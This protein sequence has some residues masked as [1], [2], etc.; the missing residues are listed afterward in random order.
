MTIAFLDIEVVTSN[1]KIDN[2]GYLSDKSAFESTSISR[3][4]EACLNDDI[5][6]ICGHNF[7]DHDK[8]FL[9]KTGFNPI[10]EKVEI[11]DTLYLSMLLCTN[12]R[13]HKLD[14]PYKDTQINIE[15]QPLG[16]SEQT[17]ALFDSL[18]Q[19][20]DK[21]DEDIKSVFYQLLKDDLHFSGFFIYKDYQF[22]SI[23]V[24]QQIQSFIEIDKAQYLDIEK[25][26]PI[27][28]AFIISFLRL[29]DQGAISLVI[30]NKYPKV[31]EL[32]KKM[33]FNEDALDIKS[34]SV[35]EFNISKF[36][37]F[38]TRVSG[39]LFDS[40]KISQEEIVKASIGSESLLAIL[41]TG[42]GKTI[43]FQ[44]PALIKAQ[45][46]KGLSVVIS[47]LQALMKDQIDSFKRKNNNFKVIAISGY[48]SP[49]ER[50]NAIS[51]VENGIVDML[52]LAPEALRSNS[53]FNALKKR[54]IERFII[55]EAH[56]FSSWGHDFRHDYYFIANTIKELEESNFQPHIPVSCFTATA[57]PE[58]IKDIKKYFQ[59]KLNITLKE[60]IASVERYNLDYSIIKTDTA[61]D[62]YEKL[63]DILSDLERSENNKNPTIIYIP[64]NTKEC[65]ELS[66]KLQKDERLEEFNLVIEPFYS[67]LD[68][69]RENGKREQNSRG[70]I[71]ILADFISN[72]VNVV[73]ATTAFGMGIDK[74]DIQ[75]I[76]HYQQ[77]DSLESYI[78][79]SGRGARDE[80]LRAK[81]IVLYSKDDFD[82]SFNQLNRSK[83]DIAEIKR[84]VGVLKKYDNK[85]LN[86][87]PKDIARK[88]GVDIEDS[89]ID[90]KV[91]IKTALLELEKHK[92]IERGRDGYK[93]FATSIKKEE[94]KE[95]MPFVHEILDP[96]KEQDP[97]IELYQGMILVMQNIIQRS[98][99][100]PIEVD[101]LSDITGVEKSKIFKVL[102]QL[103]KDGL[104]KFDNDISVYIKKSVKKDFEKYF[105]V[106]RKVLNV[107]I[108][109]ND[110]K[111]INLRNFNESDT[112]NV[113]L[114]KQII[115][116]WSHLAKL[117]GGIFTARFKNDF[118]FFQLKDEYVLRKLVEARK[119][120]SDFII[121]QLLQKLGNNKDKEIELSSNKIKFNY[122]SDTLTLESFHHTFVHLHE[123]LK[124]FEL[125]R[126]RLIYYQTLQLN[127]QN[128][129]K[130]ERAPYKAVDYND[131]LKQYYKRKIEAIHIQIIFLEKLLE[132][133][134]DKAK[135]FVEDYFSQEYGKFKKIYK[136]NEQEIGRPVTK[137]KYKQ[138]LEDLNSE[139]K[140]IFKDD[141]SQSIMTLAG[142][143]S[144][145]TKTLVHKIA[146]LITIEGNKAEYFL[147]L[148]HSRVAVSDFR[149]KLKQLIGNQ[150]Y[151]VQIHT[152]HSFAISLLGKSIDE[153]ADLQGV[154]VKAANLLE[155]GIIKMPFINMLVVD[156]YQD[157][158]E[159]SYAL[160]NAIYSNMGDKSDK[161]IIVVGD[162]DQCIKNFGDDKADTKYIQ[163][164]EQDF[165]TDSED[166]KSTFSKYQLLTNYRSR[167]NL[168]DFFNQFSTII[169]SRLKT[170]ALIPFS[171]AQGDIT[172]DFY[173]NGD[174]YS[175]LLNSIKN[176]LSTNI[177]VLARS[178]SEVLSIYS[179]L[180]ANEIKARY[181]TSENGFRL[182]CLAELQDFLQDW[183]NTKD[184]ESSRK[185]SDILYKESKNNYLKNQVIDRF[186]DEYQDEIKKGQNHFI[187]VFTEYL[188]LINFDEFSEGKSTVVVSTTHKAKGQEWDEVYLCADTNFINQ[189]SLQVEYDKRLAYV[190]I[191]RAKNNLYIHS[192]TPLFNQFIKPTVHNFASEPLETIVLLMGLKDIR[193][194]NTYSQK[195]VKNTCPMAGEIVDI[196]PKDNFIQIEKNSE[197]IA[198]LSQE[199]VEGVRRQQQRGYNLSK[200]EIENVV[201]WTDKENKEKKFKQ[202]LCKIYL[203]RDIK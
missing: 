86:L 148:A 144:G 78:Q 21:L 13:T 184:F 63:I 131:G 102:Y 196:V 128:K 56:C 33:T 161:K 64:Q 115:Q 136:L 199:M 195:G 34:F 36:R 168:V 132:Q 153:Y 23:D 50:M 188:C 174:Y 54:I 37:E 186:E 152:F 16:D 134:W 118:C 91:I 109:S 65:R 97:Y 124:S 111:S 4:K 159:Q 187:S 67:K 39:D 69:D 157:V 90:Y 113:L 62:K 17:K 35:E 125:R 150:V 147:M 79:E 173:Q 28:I 135:N 55:D 8:K 149:N 83:V 85:T 105:E 162:D 189:D 70:K 5:N 25:Q 194:S 181:I 142:P 172:L 61:E 87:S 52:Y 66:N 138:I 60:F 43:T 200:A 146:S 116:S 47:P 185:K 42:G 183:I 40:G 197:Q 176:N 145:K 137:E 143:G 6:F 92:I 198:S 31:V 110:D 123:M 203:S 89:S 72:K 167:A 94:Q 177:A 15:N 1:G 160:I 156:E 101:D 170:K 180:I 191:T 57:K 103:Q 11:I 202:V 49:I 192:K 164:F 53:I 96:K 141:K 108:A 38:D 58:V 75:T 73:I 120:L 190:A 119:N 122:D 193:L 95:G 7:I 163:K 175:N 74:P 107:L 2:L 76:I 20:F 14:K 84:I 3:V 201:E 93:I 10:F 98:K 71:D 117:K 45:K 44:I 112:N 41:P 48:L 32:L 106:E 139:Q 158:G 166:G 51:E 126:G 12:K 127:L 99:L 59:D 68:E 18:N 133:G 82:R 22:K 169:G 81:C 100:D 178:N 171:K 9:A 130:E 179:M 154:I 88:M 46:Y 30:L 155:E 27:E 165:S 104:L 26:F 182:G 114:F 80:N 129:I 140:E 24:Y 19:L 29:A 151:S 121:N 77:S